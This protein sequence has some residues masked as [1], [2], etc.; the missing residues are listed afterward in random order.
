MLAVIAFSYAATEMFLN[1]PRTATALQ[2]EGE[3]DE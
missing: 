1:K 2:Q 3:E